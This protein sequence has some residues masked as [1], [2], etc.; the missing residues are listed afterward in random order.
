MGTEEWTEH[1]Q[2]A[3]K[4]SLQRNVEGIWYVQNGEEKAATGYES[5][6]QIPED[7]NM[8]EVTNLFSPATEDRITTYG[9]KLQKKRFWLDN[10]KKNT[11]GKG[12]IKVEQID[13]GDGGLSLNKDLQRLNIN[14]FMLEMP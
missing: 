7:S 6:L 5:P 10:R 2:R 14:I 11:N 12:S 4:T 13:K 3:W 1:D 8:E 9:Y